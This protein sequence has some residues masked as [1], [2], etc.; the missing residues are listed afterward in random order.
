M[1]TVQTGERAPDLT[2]ETQDGRTVSLANYRGK[3]PVE[4]YFYPKDGT[5]ICTRQACSMRDAYQD[6][7]EAGAAVIG[8]SGDTLD[9]HRAFVASHRLPYPL[10]SDSDGAMRAA[11][12]VP[13]LFGLL[14]G[15]VTYVIDREGIVRNVFN[16]ALLAGKHVATALETVR[17]LASENR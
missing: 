17:S 1:P 9:A 11:F 2:A 14:P 12:G 3:Q 6:F 16:S 15:R 13:K 10:V 8:V 4:L 7:V 5:T